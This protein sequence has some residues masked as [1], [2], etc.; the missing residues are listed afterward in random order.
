MNGA[1]ASLLWF[2]AGLY[3]QTPVVTADVSPALTNAPDVLSALPEDT[4]LVVAVRHLAECDDKLVKLMERL[5]FPA[6]PYML[7]KGSLEIVT[8]LDDTGS[9]AIA[10]MAPM[11]S[12]G[13]SQQI[14]LLLPT[15]D[16]A[17]MLTF[18]NPKPL[19]DG[20][21]KVTLRGRGSYV[22]AKG[23][24]S[25]FGPDLQTVRHVVNAKTR[26]ADRVSAHQLE[27]FR[28]DDVSFWVNTTALP[29]SSAG[30]RS[31]ARLRRVFGVAVE[32][33]LRYDNIQGSARVETDGLAFEFCM[34]RAKPCDITTNSK[35]SGY[36]LTG[37]PNE[38][39]ALALGLTGDNG[40]TQIGSITTGI[41]STLT[42]SGV[43]D[44]SR[45]VELRRVYESLA[46]KI[47]DVAVSVSL[48]PEG[49]NGTVACT[50][51]LHAR[52]DGHALLNDI[53]RVVGL[54]KSGPFVDPRL[55]RVAENVEY[56]RAAETAGN[57]VVDHLFVNLRG[58]EDIDH[59]ALQKMFG[60]EGPLARIGVVDGKMVVITF[61]GGLP[62]FNGVVIALRSE[63]APLASQEEIR[64]SA[65]KFAGKHTLEAYV[66]VDRC[67]RLAKHILVVMDVPTDLPDMPELRA[68]VVLT[69]Q[70]A[71]PRETRIR[72]FVPT[73]VVVAVKEAMMARAARR[74]SHNN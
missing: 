49:S 72:L 4:L 58:F 44:P 17:A 48:L 55:N 57:I 13:V 43:I 1:M 74:T 21:S 35:T 69:M 73:E 51:V 9:A 32:S 3:F 16:R 12:A 42:A 11:E 61:G 15:G 10:A 64:Q 67:V 30:A 54:I 52:G 36:L 31:D 46:G 24:F 33:L 63:K 65:K 18:L 20:Y 66:S 47:T 7:L 53:E 71:G 68:P 23:R 34:V 6:S 27:R 2:T 8:G 62:H 59:E 70:Y 22:G 14:V 41:I 45:S 29:A 26:L 39:F 28:V 5:G 25:V 37:L 56:R 60:R 40:G 38:P 19:D 50:K